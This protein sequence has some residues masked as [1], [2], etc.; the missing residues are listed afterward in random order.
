MMEKF[1]DNETNEQRTKEV[2]KMSRTDILKIPE[3]YWG[4]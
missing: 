4:T 1:I 3:L 2:M